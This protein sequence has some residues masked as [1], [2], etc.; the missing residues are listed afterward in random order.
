MKDL[1]KNM[2]G[3]NYKF[4]KIDNQ[5]I[6]C[7]DWFISNFESGGWEPETFTIFEKVSDL[8]KIAIDVGSWIGVTTVWLSKRFKN[9]IAIEADQVAADAL[10][11]NLKSCDCDNVEVV[12]RPIHSESKEVIFGVNTNDQLLANEGLGSSTSQVKE[13]TTNTTD[14]SLQTITFKELQNRLNLSDVSF[15]KVDIEGGEEI[16]LEILF[17]IASEY[18]WSVLISFHLNWWKDSNI[19]RMAQIFKIP[20]QIKSATDFDTIIDNN[21]VCDYIKKNPFCN[22]FLEF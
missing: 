22:I 14:E 17:E 7:F 12:N 9:V 2:Y 10:L 20:N 1:D 19:H 6:Q 8:D 11:K 21:S 5:N 13:A 16:I 18:K 4:T 3:V 15:V